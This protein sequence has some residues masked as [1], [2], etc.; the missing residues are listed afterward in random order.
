ME[1]TVTAVNAEWRIDDAEPNFPHPSRAAMLKWLNDKIS[2]TQDAA[3]KSVYQEAL[4]QLQAQSALAIREIDFAGACSKGLP[5]R[6]AF[7]A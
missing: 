7:A 6:E 2:T 3:A 5:R 4:Q 1:Y